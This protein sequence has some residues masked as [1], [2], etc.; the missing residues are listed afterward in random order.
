MSLGS[1]H[2]DL[3]QIWQMRF[4]CVRAA[5]RAGDWPA[6]GGA[7]RLAGLVPRSRAGRRRSRRCARAGRAGAPGSAVQLACA[8]FAGRD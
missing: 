8:C 5:L 7:L 1:D 2:A 3:V 6:V 4:A